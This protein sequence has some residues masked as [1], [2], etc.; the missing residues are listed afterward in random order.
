MKIDLMENN[1]REAI[2]FFVMLI[3][4]AIV[5]E[6][7]KPKSDYNATNQNKLQKQSLKVTKIQQKV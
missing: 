1:M 3:I 6:Y 4:V 7:M 2:S 5:Y